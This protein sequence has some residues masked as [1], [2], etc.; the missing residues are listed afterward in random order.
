M[1]RALITALAVSG[2][3]LSATSASAYT[4]NPDGTGFV[5]KGEVQT[6]FGWNNQALQANAD[7][8]NF[9]V[10]TTTESETTWTCSRTTPAGGEIVQER[11]NTTTTEAQGLLDSTTRDKKQV[12]GFLI[13]GPDGELTTEIVDQ[14]GPAIGSCPAGQSGF[15]FDG[16]EETTTTTEAALYAKWNGTSELLPAPIIL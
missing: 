3:A 15:S 10:S 5:G 16:N 12:T 11:S 1:K 14:D 7:A 4:L 13:E 9:Y 2:L 6:A 8:V